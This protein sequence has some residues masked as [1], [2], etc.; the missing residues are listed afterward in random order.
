MTLTKQQ[1][2]CSWYLEGHVGAALA[3]A[4]VALD[5]VEELP[6]H[7]EHLVARH[8]ATPPATRTRHVFVRNHSQ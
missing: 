2:D 5:L 7:V 6:G 8:A 4:A 1:Q 3:V